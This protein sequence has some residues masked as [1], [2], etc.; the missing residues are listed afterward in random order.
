MSDALLLPS[1]A[2]S[3]HSP[4]GR[5]LSRLS[6]CP[7]AHTGH[8]RPPYLELHKQALY[9][10]AARALRTPVVPEGGPTASI[11]HPISGEQAHFFE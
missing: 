10:G 5:S 11:P 1:S 2:G 9:L 3:T 6:Q 4:Q 7:D 8:D